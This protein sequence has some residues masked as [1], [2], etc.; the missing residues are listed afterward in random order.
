MSYLEHPFCHVTNYPQLQYIF[1]LQTLGVDRSS[2]NSVHIKNLWQN[3]Q[4]STT[5]LLLATY[6]VPTSR[7][8]ALFMHNTVRSEQPRAIQVLYDGSCPLCRREIS[9]YQQLTPREPIIWL[10][11]AD[12][13]Q[14]LPQQ[15]DRCDAMR[16]FHLVGAQQQ[17]W[18]GAR[19][20]IRLWQALPGWRWLGYCCAVPPI[21]TLL[22]LGYRLTLKL[23]PRLQ[24]WWG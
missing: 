9:Y 13:L 16:R 14:Q 19:A 22:E 11:V 10:N 6:V 21:P 17:V 20:F 5:I 8:Q 23:R 12:Q 3:S 1:G 24:Q 2:C 7:Q 4:I 15:V 18:Q